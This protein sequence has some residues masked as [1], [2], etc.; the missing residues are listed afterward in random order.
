MGQ[1]KFGEG[2]ILDHTPYSEVHMEPTKKTTILFPPT[3]HRRLVRLAKQRGTS[4]GD[5]VR[6]RMIA[7]SRRSSTP[8]GLQ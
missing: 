4:L 6:F 5:L 8:R 1:R 3:L 7:D 2:K